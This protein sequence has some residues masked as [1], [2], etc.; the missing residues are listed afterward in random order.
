[1]RAMDALTEIPAVRQIPG[2]P[3]R[4]WFAS[5]SLDLIVWL[6][7]SGSPAGFQLCYD[8]LRAER[9]L[10]WKPDSGFLHHAV[11]DGER[12]G[13]RY[14]RTPVLVEDGRFDAVRVSELFA[15]ASATLPREIVEFVSA[16]LRQHPGHAEQGGL[17]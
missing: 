15:R 8:K 9:A 3:P 12:G 14:K 6:D 16:R 1:M 7:D 17:P 11:D 10:T 2:E 13:L 4:R 5:Q